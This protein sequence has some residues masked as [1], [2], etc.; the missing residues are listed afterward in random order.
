MDEALP[1]LWPDF[2]P[3]KLMLRC[4]RL[5]LAVFLAL[6]FG[7]PVFGQSFPEPSLYPKSWE[8]D[9]KHGMPKRIVVNARNL[10]EPK[11][12]WY[13][14]YRV[15]NNSGKEQTFLPEFDL[16]TREGKIYRSDRNIPAEVY[17]AIK[18]R[19]RNK[20]LEPPT[21]VAGV[22]RVGEDEARDSVAVWEEP[23]KRMGAFTVF[24]AGLS[25]EYA[26]LTGADGKPMADEK[27]QPIILRK[28]LQLRYHIQGDE[29]SPGDD[30][31]QTGDDRVG[32][33]AKKWVMR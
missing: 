4:G 23:L 7:A 10:G 6:A 31:V 2:P 30:V 32:R 1:V 21:S 18:S 8:L 15:T 11:A 22:I 28:T 24:A 5:I 3:E 12:Y 17:R 26:K 25:G 29:V 19:E 33:N 27:G 13:I 16:V 20:Y 9:F 14:T